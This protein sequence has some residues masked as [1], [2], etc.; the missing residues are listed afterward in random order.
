[1]RPPWNDYFMSI[2]YLVSTRATCDR[3]KVGAVLVKGHRMVASGYN[4]SPAGMPHCDDVGHE[5]K[6]IEGRD[7]CIRTLHA[8]SNAIDFAGRDAEGCTLF[9]TVVP[10]YDCA[11]RIIN[12]RITH[13]LYDEYYQSR[14][15]ELVNDLFNQA[16][17]P[18][19]RWQ[20]ELVAVTRPPR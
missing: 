12:A 9:T 11:K 18:L 14:S 19:E 1:M 2:A 8:E 20:G 16:G 13:V 10:C 15:T 6:K 4:G 3:K 5:L 17:V 7:S